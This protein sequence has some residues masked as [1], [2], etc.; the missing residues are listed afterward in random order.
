MLSSA[1]IAPRLRRY[2]ATAV[3]E[4]ALVLTILLSLSF[5]AV[6]YGYAFF[7]KHSLQGAARE[8]ARA[9]I[10]DGGDNTAVTTAVKNYMTAAGFTDSSKYTIAITDTANAA[11]NAAT[12]TRGQ[13]VKVTISY[14]W[15][16]IPAAYRPLGLMSTTTLI[17]GAT[18]MRKEG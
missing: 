17:K 13:P 9:G 7:L 3:L 1:S 4:T 2:R 18:V 10:V 14:K 6:E 5:G 15:G 12:V 16:N 11:V 8:G